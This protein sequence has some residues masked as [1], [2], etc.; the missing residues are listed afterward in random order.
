MSGINFLSENYIDNSDL[1]L[2]TGSEN[3]Q[4]PLSNIKNAATVKKFRST[5]NTV[6][7]EIDLQ[8]TRAL[9]AL[10]IAGDATGTFG[11]TAASFKTSVTTDFS[12][13]SAINVDISAEQNMGYVFFTQVSHRFVELT[14][15]GTGSFCEVGS[16]F[17]GE[18]IN[19]PL[20]SFSVNSFKYKYQDRSRVQS[21]RYGQKFIDELPLIKELGGTIEYATKTE[22]E[23]L[24]DMFIYHGK[25][26][27]LW[28]FVDP[29]SEAMNEGK[30]KLTM[31][32]YMPQMPEWR[33]VGGQLYSTTI[34]LE[35]AI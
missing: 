32:A 29:D 9:D 24:D 21:N 12:G 33:S 30:Y 26:R 35:Q 3:A 25:K 27:P 31:Y 11:V 16:I 6:V 28:V 17:I 2:T 5:G 34:N 13:S 10:A 23:Q 20:N 1:S 22:Q 19:L 18:R 7:I 8:Q 14:L 15:T 4:F